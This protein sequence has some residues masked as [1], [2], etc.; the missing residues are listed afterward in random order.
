MA[1]TTTPGLFI[2]FE[3]GDGCGKSTQSQILK[4]H[5][6]KAGRQVLLT[7]EPGGTEMGKSIRSLLLHGQDVDPV[8]E[9]LLYAADRAHHVESLIRPALEA[10]K[11]VITDR[12]LASSIAYQGYGR[13]QDLELIADLGEIATRGLTPDLTFLLEVAP[14]T[15]LRRIETEADRFEKL[16]AGF[17]EKVQAGFREIA[18][19]DPLSW[20]SI[21]GGG[22]IEE[23]AAQI[24]GE[25]QRRGL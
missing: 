7:R 19:K 25:V 1:A 3:G 16:G 11:V 10:G 23:I 5:F 9:A 2:A 6:K 12:F 4:E 8:T 20:V 15:A 22:S 14:Q 24:W 17:Q 21:V 13:G 18:A